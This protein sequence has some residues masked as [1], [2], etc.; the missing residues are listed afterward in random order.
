MSE[1]I[2]KL[3]SF[4][5]Y[6][7]VRVFHLRKIF[8]SKSI[9]FEDFWKNFNKKNLPNDLCLMIDNFLSS[10]SK[11]FISG[12]WK[13]NNIIDINSLSKKGIE[14]YG[15]IFFHYYTWYNWSDEEIEGLLQELE[16]KII[17]LKVNIYK[18]HNELTFNESFKLNILLLSL[19]ISLKNKDEFI[20]LDKLK[21]ESFCTN[22]HPFIEIDNKKITHDKINSL[23]ELSEIKNLNLI[24]NKN[25]ILEIG[26]G[27]GRL[28]DTILSIYDNNKY[29]ICDIPLALY[30]SYFRLKKRFKEKKIF[31]VLEADNKNE[32]QKVLEDY[33]VVFIFPHQLKYINKN[34]FDL[35]LSISSFHEMESD[36]IRFYMENID[37]VSKSL[38]FTVWKETLL[39]FSLKGTKLLADNKSYFIKESWKEISSKRNFFPNNIIQKAFLID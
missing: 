20:H 24:N 19:Y 8:F 34:F 1:N 38:Y 26:A 6:I 31:F 33:D 3:K 9:N 7:Q 22:S 35:T 5:K 23:L 21:D 36:V 17:D 13:Y 28:A 39:P 29:V 18:K 16:N 27:S 25:N 15:E 10:E 12:W 32:L 14:N 11:K 2:S 30:V 37:R 4:F